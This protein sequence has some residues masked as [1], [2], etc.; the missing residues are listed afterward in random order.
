MTLGQ[1]IQELRKGLGLS[2]EELGERMGVSRQAI[3][4]WEG[5]Q[6][7][8]E[9]DNLIA[10][11]RL[12]GLTVGQL[13]GVEQPVPAPPAAPAKM[14]RRM[15]LLMSG[16]GAV[17]AV[18]SVMT[19]LLWSQLQA[20]DRRTVLD[21][22]YVNCYNKELFQTAECQLSGVDYGSPWYEGG[23]DLALEFTLRPVQQFKGWSVLGYTAEIQGRAAPWWLEPGGQPEDGD[24]PPRTEHLAADPKTGKAVLTLSGYRG[25]SA[26]VWAILREDSTGRKLETGVVFTATPEIEPSTL[27]LTAIH[28]EADPAPDALIPKS[29]ALTLPDPRFEK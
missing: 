17:L 4:K 5:D 7:I 20:L 23:Q 2:Q 29:I 15:K 18:L 9:L 13:L 21:E 26:T 28:V 25:E 27:A 10:L 8:P 14:P 24:P 19:G 11:S 12:F 16:M 22:A 1:R 3:S 6:T